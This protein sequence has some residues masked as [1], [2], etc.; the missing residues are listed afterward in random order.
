M[1][2]GFIFDMD[3]VIINSEPIFDKHFKVFAEEH[4]FE[5]PHD[6]IDKLRGL[7]DLEIWTHIKKDYNLPGE[8]L[9]YNEALL[10]RVNNEIIT[11]DSLFPEPGILELIAK[12]KKASITIAV[13]SS[14]DRNRINLILNKFK[15]TNYFDAIV[16]A[17]DVERAKPDPAIYLL[18]ADKIER[19]PKDCWVIEDSKH[20]I[21]AAKEAG[22]RC[23]AYSGAYENAG[24]DH[25]Q[26]DMKIKSINELDLNHLYPHLNE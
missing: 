21:T 26:A 4:N 25:D 2:K 12:L 8:P 24:Q 19:S 9:E 1:D 20:G 18:A 15:I 3:G 13:A 23:I 17:D 7:D 14:A 16:S 22:M 5:L 10:S 6:Y 11:N